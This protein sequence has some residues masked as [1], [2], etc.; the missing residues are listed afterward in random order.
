MAN[1]AWDEMMG[2]MNQHSWEEKRPV[3]TASTG[4]GSNLLNAI[5]TNMGRDTPFQ[6]L[7]KGMLRHKRLG[8]LKQAR[9]EGLDP[10]QGESYYERMRE[11]LEAA[12]DY[13]GANRA[14]QRS[15]TARTEH[16]ARLKSEA[17]RPHIKR[18]ADLA[19]EKQFQDLP[20]E[21]AKRDDV[22]RQAEHA[23][24]I[25][26][27]GIQAGGTKLKG[28]AKANATTVS[29]AIDSH[30]SDPNSNLMSIL[31]ATNPNWTAF[32]DQWGA[33]EYDSDTVANRQKLMKDPL[34]AG[35][36]DR[37][38]TS[39][40]T[41]QETF[42]FMNAKTAVTAALYDAQGF[43]V[44][45]DSEGQTRARHRDDGTEYVID[46]E[47]TPR[48]VQ[49]SSDV[50][51]AGT[52]TPTTE[53]PTTETDGPALFGYDLRNNPDAMQPFPLNENQQEIFQDI[54]RSI[55]G[56]PKTMQQSLY[57]ILSG[58]EDMPGK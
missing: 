55:R 33:G 35:L 4:P 49:V 53:T 19:I 2:A 52:E 40:L 57:F 36:K 28:L 46:S 5:A 10:A 22:K 43:E 30:F 11:L 48:K 58:G 41:L 6:T 42:P 15:I 24:A 51:P 32:E 9:E 39:S 23:N 50:V 20:S 13:D 45:Q 14:Y 29:A 8:A 38:L 31:A 27:A 37:I 44:W 18:S 56:L 26:L 16:D 7:S 25:E 54:Q 1:N 3:Y 21:G 47:G 12:G 17:T 34:Y